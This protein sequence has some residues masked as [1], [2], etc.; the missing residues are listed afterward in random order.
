MISTHS[1]LRKSERG[2]S[3]VRWLPWTRGSCSLARGGS[4]PQGSW[5]SCSL[6]QDREVGVEKRAASNPRP[7][8]SQAVPRVPSY[9]TVQ[10]LHGPPNG[11]G[12][13]VVCRPSHPV[14]DPFSHHW[15]PNTRNPITYTRNPSQTDIPLQIFHMLTTVQPPGALWGVLCQAGL[16][17]TW[18]QPGCSQ[19]VHPPAAGVDTLVSIVGPAGMC[20]GVLE[21]FPPG[22]P[23]VPPPTPRIQLSSC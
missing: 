3:G 1:S 13:G 6:A 15:L 22:A 10:L 17:G 14:S 23:R 11:G 12:G 5:G 2:V 19:S 9:C 20:L 16:G 18:T 7:T 21:P 8:A 4:R